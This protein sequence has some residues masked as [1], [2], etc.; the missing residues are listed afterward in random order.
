MMKDVF[1]NTKPVQ[2]ELNEWWFNGRIIV[3]QDDFRLPAWISFLDS[4]ISNTA[5]IHLSK[6]DAVKYALDN[7]FFEPDNL[8]E[9][10][11]GLG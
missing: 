6:A 8:L 3:K 1:G 4:E 10:Y 2:I 5:T 9:D 11:I 7:P